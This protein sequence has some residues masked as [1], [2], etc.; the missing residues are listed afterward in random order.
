MK[1]KIAVL[2]IDDPIGN[3][4]LEELRNIFENTIDVDYFTPDMVN[5]PYI[6]NVDLILYTDPSILIEIIDNIKCNAPILMMKRTISKEVID[7]LRV[8]ESG[9]SAYVA[10]INS[11]MANETLATLYRLGIKNLKLYPYYDGIVDPKEVD[12]IITPNEFGCIKN[13]KGEIINIGNRLFDASTVLDI[14]AYLNIERKFAER[15]IKKYASRVPTYWRGLKNTLYD[16]KMLL[17]QL[18]ILLNEFD[19]GI[20]LCDEKG[21]IQLS[22][23]KASEIFG[24]EKE[25]LEEERLSQLI[26]RNKELSILESSDEINGEMVQFR[27]KNLIISVKKVIYDEVYFGRLIILKYYNELLRE[28]N[29]LHKKL[30]GKGYYSKYSFEDILGQHSKLVEAINVSKKISN[31]AS[32]VLLIGE[33]GTGKELFAGAIHNYS[34]RKNKPFIAINCATLPSNLLESELFGYEEGSFTGALKGGKMGVFEKASGGTLFL[35]EIGEIPLE[36]QARLLRALEEK[37]VMKV[38]GDSIISVNVRII[39]ASNRDLEVMVN[40][41]TFRDDLYYRLNV[42]QINLPPLRAHK[43]D[44]NV[45]IENFFKIFNDHRTLDDP[46]MAFCQNYDW[47]GNV[48][49]LRN[50]IEYMLKIDEGMFKVEN[51]PA[52]QKKRVGLKFQSKDDKEKFV[53]EILKDLLKKGLGT[54]RRSIHEAYCKKYYKISETEIREILKKLADDGVIEIYPGRKGC[55]LKKI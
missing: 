37:E 22:N 41:R 8:I 46:F 4:F 53:I 21:L 7:T 13:L 52:S 6:S 31:S 44:I 12:Y 54:G 9:K 11:F 5:K 49:E 50:V 34:E 51:L 42:F 33:S 27:N 25:Y 35:D 26:V 32:S 39:A 55:Q 24:I 16:K 43:S 10:N 40:E 45:L 28:Q 3:Y 20:I 47:P 23:S 19:S 2:A 38:G 48:R 18:E 36:L 1:K 14:I 29:Q 30:V 17:G 15:V